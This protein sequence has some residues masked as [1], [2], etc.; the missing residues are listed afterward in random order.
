MRPLWIL[1]E[2]GPELPPPEVYKEDDV[3]Y[4]DY[5]ALSRKEKKRF[6]RKLKWEM[7][8]VTVKFLF[9]RTE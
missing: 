9:R 5:P 4:I 7:V 1:G 2:N 8:K 3:T 6:M